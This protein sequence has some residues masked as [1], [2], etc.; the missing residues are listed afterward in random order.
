MALFPKYL[1]MLGNMATTSHETKRL[2]S[3]KGPVLLSSSI[4]CRKCMVSFMQGIVGKPISFTHLFEFELLSSIGSQRLKSGP[5]YDISISIT[6]LCRN[7]DIRDISIT[8]YASAKLILAIMLSPTYKTR[9]RTNCTYSQSVGFLWGKPGA[10]FSMIGW[11]VW[12][13]HTLMSV[14]SSL[15]HNHN[16]KHKKNR[17][18]W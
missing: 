6:S 5:H 14:L 3:G 1:L 18:F 13:I 17:K 12:F 9:W 11:I 10:K 4:L 2:S 8:L 16:H 15:G 7:E